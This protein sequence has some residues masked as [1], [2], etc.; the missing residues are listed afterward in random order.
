[1]GKSAAPVDSS[2]LAANATSYMVSGLTNG[3]VNNST[4]KAVNATGSCPPRMRSPGA[5]L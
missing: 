1:M 3:T 2:P 4:V 5:H